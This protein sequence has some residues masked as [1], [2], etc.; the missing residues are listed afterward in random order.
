MRK[1]L[2]LC[3]IEFVRQALGHFVKCHFG[4]PSPNPVWRCKRAGLESELVQTRTRV[5]HNKNKTDPLNQ[6]RSSTP[7]TSAAPPH[8][9]VDSFVFEQND[10]PKKSAARPIFRP[11][12]LAERLL[13]EA[14][15]QLE[16]ESHR[17]DLMENLDIAEEIFLLNRRRD[18]LS[19]IGEYRPIALLGRGDRTSAVAVSLR[20]YNDMTLPAKVRLRTGIIALFAL[21]MC[22]DKQVAA[23]HLDGYARLAEEVDPD[24]D[25]LTVYAALA[26]CRV[27]N[28]LAEAGLTAV[29]S[30]TALE[31][32]LRTMES[33]HQIAAELLAWL[34]AKTSQAGNPSVD[35][36]GVLLTLT[37]LRCAASRVIDVAL[38]FAQLR[39]EI[40]SNR[41]ITALLLQGRAHLLR[42]QHDQ[43]A[44]VLKAAAEQAQTSAALHLQAAAHFQAAMVLA[45]LGHTGKAWP[46]VLHYSAIQHTKLSRSVLRAATLT[47]PPREH[48][49]RR[50]PQTAS[51]EHL[52]QVQSEPPYLRRALRYIEIHAREDVSVESIV[53]VAGVSRRTL[54]LAFRSFRAM[55]PLA[56][57]RQTRL[58]H[59]HQLLVG[60][61]LSIA[62]IREAVGY[63]NASMFSRD[64]RSHFSVSPL[65]ARRASQK[66]S[67]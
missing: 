50:A 8:R 29:P 61:E 30:L 64:F 56:Y 67:V 34:E 62:Q 43:A 57:L 39:Q 19:M 9:D 26:R 7:E 65:A 16:A 41:P 33:V 10:M 17:S 11:I 13:A 36:P 31:R 5:M 12:D 35:D 15:A 44:L 40:G 51:T 48:M 4:T 59:A 46:H 38:A 21:S 14:H 42:G 37:F 23:A 28:A 55:S 18:R 58:E 54:E 52:R 32:P 22:D 66:T 6:R 45:H 1:K 2:M 49:P 24:P 53:A 47:S 60:T 3:A 63:R 27:Y 25:T 20:T